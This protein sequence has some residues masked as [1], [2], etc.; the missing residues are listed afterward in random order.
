VKQQA[1]GVENNRLVVTAAVTTHSRTL[2]LMQ[3]VGDAVLLSRD[4]ITIPAD[5]H[6][7]F[8]RAQLTHNTSN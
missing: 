8:I 6:V 2:L 7:K 4:K 5:I 1:A 3:F